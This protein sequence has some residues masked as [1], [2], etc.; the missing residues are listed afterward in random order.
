[1]SLPAIRVRSLL[2]A[3]VV[4]AIACAGIVMERRSRERARYLSVR[5]YDHC[6]IIG[7]ILV[8][9]AN[10]NELP[11]DVEAEILAGGLRPTLVQPYIR[12]L[13]RRLSLDQR[14]IATYHERMS[15]EYLAAMLRPPW[16][17]SRHP[18][19]EGRLEDY[20][21]KLHGKAE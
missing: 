9:R 14:R 1:M 16:A 13:R 17:R 5:Y 10:P 3:V 8:S 4:A 12:R 2:I 15:K 6:R 20:E 7:A 11:K 21:K 19:E 18:E